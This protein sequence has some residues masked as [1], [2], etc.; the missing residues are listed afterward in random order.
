MIDLGT[1]TGL[2][3]IAAAKLGVKQV[4]AIDNNPMACEVARRNVALNNCGDRVT[5]K[6]HD[7]LKG[8]PDLEKYDLVVANL[9]TPGYRR[10]DVKFEEILSKAL[11][12]DGS[13]DL[14][15]LEPELFNPKNTPLNDK[16]N[17]V[18]L[19]SEIG[20]LIENSLRYKAYIR[21]LNKKYNQIASAID[22]K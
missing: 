17:D 19:E 1:G 21:I 8:I 3:A 22:V 2:L 13:V 16:G 15:D 7:L 18:N 14:C 10:I 6:L 4:T 9:E 20:Q 11:D 12:S 5:V